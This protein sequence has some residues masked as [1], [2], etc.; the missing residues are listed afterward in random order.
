MQKILL[1]ALVLLMTATSCRQI[2]AKRVKGNGSVGTETR[3]ASNFNSIDVSGSIDVFVTQSPET[4]IRIEGD[5]N[6]LEYLEVYEEGGTL[7][8]HTRKGVNIKP[9]RSMKVYVSNPDFKNFEA[10]GACNIIGQSMI[11]TNE[12]VRIDLSGSSDVD[13]Q[14]DAPRIDTE[15]SGA[16][17]VKLSGKTK[18]FTV[19]GSGSTNVK[20]FDLLAENVRIDISGAGDAQVFASVKLDVD[21]S[22]AGNVKYKG[23]AN[24]TQD[25]SGAGSVRKQD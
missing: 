7:R 13:M 19:D 14:I 16:G 22:G 20:C 2:F 18:D 6:L 23:N 24:V 21:V 12:K 15:V 8:I 10:S 3:Q 9:S 1:F 11:R 5:N 4:S 17:T 25:I